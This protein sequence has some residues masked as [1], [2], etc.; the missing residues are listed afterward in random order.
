[1]VM[2]CLYVDLLKRPFICYQH[3]LGLLTDNCKEASGETGYR[4]EVARWGE[5]RKLLEET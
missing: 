5:S 3:I 1:M 4:D 2:L